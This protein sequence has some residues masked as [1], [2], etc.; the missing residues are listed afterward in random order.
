MA[1]LISCETPV[2]I[3]I[4]DQPPQIVIEGTIETGMPPVVL[5]S[6]TRGFFEPTSAEDIANSYL[7]NAEV[8]VNGI[9]LTR[10]CTDEIPP[11][12]E[13]V[14]SEL[15]GILPE[16]LDDVRICA[17]IGTDQELIGQENTTYDLKVRVDEKEITSTTHIPVIH[18]PDSVWFRLWA[19]SPQYGYVFC[20]V[21]DPDTLNNAYR[22]FTKR[23]GPN[24]NNN[25]IDELYYPPFQSAFIDE[26]FNGETVEVGFVRGMP[27]NSIRA[28]DTGEETGFFEIGD[29]FVLKFTN[30]T[31][32]TYDFFLT[33]EAQ[34]G[35][36]GSPFASPSNVISNINGGLGIWAGYATSYDTVYAAP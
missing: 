21:T 22:V 35:T 4:P 2:D 3:E 20:N 7:D 16:D 5:V 28:V 10:V 9:Q 8:Y 24:N 32:P 11:E 18:P 34:Q 23:I 1:V 27:P 15:I 17:Y 26:F 29:R 6:Q 19:N 30:I 25:P 36:N 12:L 31:K 14:V 13:D 33:Y